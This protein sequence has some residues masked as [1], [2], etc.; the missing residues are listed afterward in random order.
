MLIWATF[1]H[2][3]RNQPANAH[4]Q[5]RGA[6]RAAVLVFIYR[7]TWHCRIRTFELCRVLEFDEFATDFEN[8][9]NIS[10]DGT[11]SQCNHVRVALP[12]SCAAMLRV[13]LRWRVGGNGSIW[14]LQ[15][16][17]KGCDS[18]LLH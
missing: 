4:Q 5:L 9:V 18:F 13:P 3:V 12:V 7:S 14:L 6:R 17:D 1:L 11:L 16:C 15:R 8:S 2:T 10:E